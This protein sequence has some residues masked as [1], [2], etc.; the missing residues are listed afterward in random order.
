[1]FEMNPNFQKHDVPSNDFPLIPNGNYRCQLTQCEFVT[2]KTKSGKNAGK[3]YTQFRTV[4][5]VL[6]PDGSTRKLWEN[7]TVAHE[8]AQ[9]DAQVAGMLQK[10]QNELFDLFRHVLDAKFN[11]DVSQFPTLTEQNAYLMN[12]AILEF[13]IG[14]K[15]KDKGSTERE[16]FVKNFYPTPVAQQQVQQTQPAQPVQQAQFQ[17]QQQPVQHGGAQVNQQP[18][19]TTT[20][21]AT[22]QAVPPFMQQQG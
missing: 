4:V 2:D 13:K 7:L 17:Q 8:A 14:S 1:M 20:G 10:S 18:M 19:Q 15:K 11:G 21:P 6:M 12:D 16:N 5:D 3:T 22:Q 9:G